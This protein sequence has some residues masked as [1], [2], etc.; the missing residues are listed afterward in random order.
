VMLA[1]MDLDELQGALG[2]IVLESAYLER[3]L[4]AAFS[5]LVGSKYVA[6]IDGRMTA[7]SLIE[8]CHNIARVH[9][10]IAET[11]KT[12]LAGALNLCAE[13]NTRRNRAI[14]DAW[15]YRPGNVMVTLQS[16]RNS[17]DVTVTARTLDELR[18][19]ADQIQRAADQLAAAI[20]AALGPG[21]MRLED[22]LRAE[23]GRGI[24]ADLG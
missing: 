1:A 8:D 5:A 19:L 23:L 9:N 10:G 24:S 11:A 7:H 4:R 13:V 18:E 17:Q 22:E 2:A 14:H 21:S 20:T 6:V 16:Q 15:A 3:S 12:A